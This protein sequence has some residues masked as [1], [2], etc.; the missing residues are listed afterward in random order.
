MFSI[1]NLPKISGYE[2]PTIENYIER[3]HM[4]RHLLQ[5]HPENADMLNRRIN[6][7]ERLI[8]AYFTSNEFI[9]F[10]KEAR[11]ITGL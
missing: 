8:S 2:M 3:L 5:Q 1:L 4:D 6:A 9:A 7:W 10:Y 11:Q